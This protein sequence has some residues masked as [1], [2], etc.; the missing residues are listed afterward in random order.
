[1]IKLRLIYIAAG[2]IILAAF[3][4]SG[5]RRNKERI[6]GYSP[7]VETVRNRKFVLCE[8]P[9]FE[10]LSQPEKAFA[11][12]LSK[13][14]ISGDPIIYKQIHPDGYMLKLFTDGPAGYSIGM[15]DRLKSE[16]EEYA[17]MFWANHSIY[18]RMTGIK[19]VPMP[20]RSKLEY[21]VL[22]SLSN[23]ARMGFT[24]HTIL[25]SL[26]NVL[27]PVIFDTT[28]EPRIDGPRQ[29]KWPD[30][31]F[32]GTCRAGND[33]LPGGVFSAELTNIVDNLNSAC[34]YCSPE[35]GEMVRL[36]SE[37]LQTGDDSLYHRYYQRW[38]GYS[39]KVDWALGFFPADSGVTYSGTAFGGMVFL[40]DASVQALIGK[41]RENYRDFLGFESPDANFPPLD[42]SLCNVTAGELLTAAG[43]WG[44]NIPSSM[45][46]KSLDEN[47]QSGKSIIL[48]NVLKSKGEARGR[49]SKS[50]IL[51]K[52]CLE[53][54]EA[55]G[56][57]IAQLSIGGISTADLQLAEELAA[58]IIALNAVTNSVC[59][60]LQVL[61]EA[62]SEEEVWTWFKTEFVCENSSN[63]SAYLKSTEFRALR[64]LFNL[65]VS[66][67]TPGGFGS[68]LDAITA[69][70]AKGR[71]QDDFAELMRFDSGLSAD[72]YAKYSRSAEGN[73]TSPVIIT[74]L[75]KANTDKMGKIS[76]VELDYP[77]SV[78]EYGN[79]IAENSRVL[80]TIR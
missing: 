69:R 57:P 23:G 62:I 79:Y 15:E 58:D 64:I 73:I 36:L 17:K 46:F 44:Y 2:C 16:A 13:G 7:V 51:K 24:A 78:I 74:P 65:C 67:T 54:K 9:G 14:V 25:D 8:T 10:G 40:Q 5:C 55:I 18:D 56:R 20:N 76:G 60:D 33:T 50:V 22:I 61:P 42:F 48:L 71:F 35:T 29:R 38:L 47:L 53:L 6:S 26:F 45:N 41:I 32:T 43:E 4:L 70:I 30:A 11:Y 52:A 80:K 49:D 37:Y 28:F 34:Q 75:L 31:E 3:F 63:P 66:D 68:R 39:G 27:E 72:E 12:Y 77:E 21:S 19:F 1:M 59:L